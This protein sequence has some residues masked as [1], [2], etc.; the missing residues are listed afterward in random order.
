MADGTIF[1]QTQ[2]TALTAGH[3]V[4]VQKT[5]A[6]TASTSATF[7][8]MGGLEIATWDANADQTGAS[9]ML[10]DISA[11]AWSADRNLTLPTG[12]IG[13]RIGV[14]VSGEPAS[15]YEAILK[16]ATGVSI[17]G[18]TAATEWGRIF[19][20]GEIVIFRCTAA[21]NWLVEVDGRIP[22]KVVMLRN[23]QQ[24]NVVS[25][26]YT[27]VEHD[28]IQI[29]THGIATVGSTG[30]GGKVTIRRAGDYIIETQCMLD[31]VDSGGQVRASIYVDSVQV[32]IAPQF[33]SASSGVPNAPA[34]YSGNFA[35]GAVIEQYIHHNA[36][37][38][39]VIPNGNTSWL[40]WNGMIVTEVLSRV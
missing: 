35:K 36:G 26:T 16:G 10:Y 1:D 38:N 25:S 34:N 40:A 2:E 23:A 21:N 12:S 15:T 4:L 24:S 22:A 9:G 32:S 3:R 29:D 20:K 27:A 8:L 31:D 33:C 7:A 28:T 18:G 14:F 17:Q 11:A 39:Q 19:E 6:G 13:E 30:V 5:S 37:T